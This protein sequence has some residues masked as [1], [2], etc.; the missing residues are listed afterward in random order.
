M[1]TKIVLMTTK[2][3][4]LTLEKCLYFVSNPTVWDRP[5]RLQN[6]NYGPKS[7]STQKISTR[8]KSWKILFSLIIVNLT[9]NWHTDMVT[10][11]ES[12]TVKKRM[13]TLEKCLYFVSNPTCKVQSFLQFCH[14]CRPIPRPR[15]HYHHYM[16]MAEARI[17]RL[18]GKIK[19]IIW[20]FEINK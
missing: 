9:H 12:M 16:A 5:R 11:I 19:Y 3:R 8:T 1:V 15:Y 20:F 2:K 4:M 18:R 6:P 10:K 7:Y 14:L 13:L 17:Y